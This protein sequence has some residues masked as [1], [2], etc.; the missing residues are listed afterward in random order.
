ML[1]LFTLL[2][3]RIKT[4][5][6]GKFTVIVFL[7][8]VAAAFLFADGLLTPAISV[9]SAMEGLKTINPD[10]EVLVVPLSLIILAGLFAVQF[11]GTDKIGKIFGPVMMVW[12][13]VIGGLG[14]FQAIKLPEVF[15][16]INPMHAISYIGHVNLHIFVVL[17]CVILSA[18]GAEALYADLGHFGKRPIRIGWF[19]I[20]GLTLVS[21]YFG[22]AALILNDPKY[23]GN[24]FF[25]LAGEGIGSI[26]L[27]VLATLATI[28]A[29]QALISGVASISSQ[30]IQMTLLPRMK[31]TH[32]NQGHQGQI[33]VPFVNALL[34][35]GSIALVLIFETS[36]ALA[37]AYT[38]AI[39]GTML[40]TTICVYWVAKETWKLNPFLLYPTIAFFLFV[41]IALVVSTATKVFTGAWLP[42]LI[43]V[44]LAGM[45][46]LW[47]K[48]RHHLG[49]EMVATAMSMSELENVKN[50]GDV[51]VYEGVGF[52]MSARSDTLPQAL[53]EQIRLL[54]QMPSQIVVVTVRPVDVPFADSEPEYIEINPH[55]SKVIID[56]GFMESRNIP[57]ALR[58]SSL[59]SKFD[60]SKG[61]Y[62]LTDR[63][64]IRKKDFGLNPSEEVIFTALHRNAAKASQFFN[65][66]DDRVMAFDI[67][68]NV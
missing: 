31:I 9:V 55:I 23:I 48:G 44:S 25:G 7:V 63:T 67:K 19:A 49:E 30:A 62:F 41:D 15:Q 24:S 57:E 68:M 2:P 13:L 10:L 60:E 61:I 8:L 34:A 42:L 22:Q 52:Y 5:Q 12:F 58:H 43:G 6:K 18:T 65:L 28:I 37:G 54:K 45:M 3:Q 27:V 29:S 11:K 32:T 47:R 50:K 39:S 64:L 21:C 20:A 1:A 53:Q 51:N 59:K 36:A 46:W 14:L 33:Y 66:P 56:N 35:L 4:A 40:I 38:F 16:A 26:V 17:S